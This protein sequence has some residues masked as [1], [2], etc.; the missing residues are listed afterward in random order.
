MPRKPK[1]DEAEIDTRGHITLPVD[2]TEYVLRPSFEAI[3]SIERQLGRS[4]FDLA[5]DST[6]GRLSFE[7]M[8]VIASEMMRAYGKSNPE[9]PLASS[10]RGAK[11]ERLS[12]LIYEA[13]GPRICARITVLLMGALTGGYTASGEVKPVATT[14]N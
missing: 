11:A 3:V 12:E 7:D 10:Y 1:P 13:G 6:Q 2:G 14:S 9:D 4:L 5:G 8:G